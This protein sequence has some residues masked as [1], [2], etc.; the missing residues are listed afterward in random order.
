M[1]L[2][3]N[4]SRGQHWKCCS[5]FAFLSFATSLTTDIVG[6]SVSVENISCMYC[7]A[8]M[9]VDICTSEN[10]TFSTYVRINRVLEKPV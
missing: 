10:A 7:E 1:G 3:R 9:P 2:H 6:T 4:S 5:C 8:Y